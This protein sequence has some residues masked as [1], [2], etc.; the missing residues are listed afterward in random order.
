MGDDVKYFDRGLL[1]QKSDAFVFNRKFSCTLP[2]LP[3]DGIGMQE[4]LFR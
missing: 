1:R 3:G 2:F 4:N